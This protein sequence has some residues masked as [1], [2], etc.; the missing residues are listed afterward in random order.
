M[1]TKAKKRQAPAAK[2]RFRALEEARDAVTKLQT[3]RPLL[4]R[5]DEETLAILI[6]RQLLDHLDKSLAEAARGK[7]EPLSRILK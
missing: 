1:A 7:T 6:D 3:L 4:S 2:S 5:A